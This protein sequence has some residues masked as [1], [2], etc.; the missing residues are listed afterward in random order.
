MHSPLDVFCTLTELFMTHITDLLTRTMRCLKYNYMLDGASETLNNLWNILSRS[1][2]LSQKHKF[3]CPILNKFKDTQFLIKELTN[4]LLLTFYISQTRN[5][6]NLVLP[7]IF[8]VTTEDKDTN[9]PCQTN[10]MEERG[11]YRSGRLVSLSYIHLCFPSPERYTVVA[12]TDPQ[13]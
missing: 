4:Y 7:L 11:E 9:S 8:E 13:T 2:C 10:G 1:K 6:A 3:Q 12:G 5:W